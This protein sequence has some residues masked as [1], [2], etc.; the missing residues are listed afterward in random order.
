MK[1]HP[2][3]AEE[4]AVLQEYVRL[5]AETGI[6]WWIKKPAKKVVVGTQAG[7]LRA[8]GYLRF[9]LFNKRY[10]CHRVIYAFVNGPFESELDHANRNTSDNRPSNLRA[11]TRTQQNFNKKPA[12][13]KTGF[14]GVYKHSGNTSGHVKVYCARIK[15]AKKYKTLGYYETP[16]EA[17]SAYV[18]AARAL[19]GSFFA[20]AY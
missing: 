6:L 10:L 3:T 18:A 15:N 11:A 4:I 20:G 7:K 9:Q 13:N 16:E 14:T 12:F 2:I 5:D 1:A 17:H 19:H 8:D